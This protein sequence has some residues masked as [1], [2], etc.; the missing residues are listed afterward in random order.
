MA[1]V[2]ENPPD[3]SDSINRLGTLLSA[4]HGIARALDPDPVMSEYDRVC[5]YELTMLLAEQLKRCLFDIT[6]FHIAMTDTKGAA[7]AQDQED[8]GNDD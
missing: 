5:L 4:T 6:H 2:P 1:I 8:E 7:P 3:L